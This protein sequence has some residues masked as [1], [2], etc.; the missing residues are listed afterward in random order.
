[1]RVAA[2]VL[3]ETWRTLDLLAFASGVPRGEI[4]D[5]WAR[6]FVRR[7]TAPTP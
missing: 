2:L 6:R 5:R 3:P 4:L 1:V 7:K